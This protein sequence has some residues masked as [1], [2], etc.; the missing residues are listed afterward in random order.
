MQPL[1]QPCNGRG[2]ERERDVQQ[3][4]APLGSGSRG[5]ITSLEPA[6]Q[7]G[8]ISDAIWEHTPHSE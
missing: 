8:P 6:P 1:M 5:A 2:G 7:H 3:W 4:R